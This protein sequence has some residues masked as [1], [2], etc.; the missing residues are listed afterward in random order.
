MEKR[1]TDMPFRTWIAVA[2]CVALLVTWAPSEQAQGAP[3]KKD[4]YY[5]EK[6]GDVVWEVKTDRPLI[7]LTFDDGP[8]PAQTNEIL[9]LLKQ[10]EARCTFFVVGKR[11]E[12][13]PDTALRIVN[14]GHEIAN[15]TYNHI[16]FQNS[17]EQLIHSELERTEEAILKATGQH[18]VLFRPPGGMF[19]EKLV[20]TANGMGLKPIIWSWH[21]DTRDWV[22]PGVRQITNHV[23]RNAHNGDIVLF[24]DH[25]DG[26]SQTVQA[27]SAILPELHKRGFQ[28]VTVSEMLQDAAVQAPSKTPIP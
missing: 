17:T 5:Y 9:D 1:V 7:A 8:D 15:H 16:Y 14:E 19:N 25:V 10:Y 6:R 2:A 24:H 12:A 13:F 3:V 18:S 27:L 23:L 4:R 11:V 22:R 20:L 28:F 21:Q 26:N